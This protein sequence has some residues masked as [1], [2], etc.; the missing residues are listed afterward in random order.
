MI[1]FLTDPSVPTPGGNCP[2]CGAPMS[3]ERCAYCGTS[4]SAPRK[5]VGV[6]VEERDVQAVRLLHVFSPE[7]Q[8][9]ERDMR[10]MKEHEMSERLGREL[11]ENGWV[12]VRTCVNPYTLCLEIQFIL[13]VQRPEPSRV[14]EKWEDI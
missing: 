8:A 9:S 6:R 10:R 5:V 4:K 14:R 2:N 13:R 11:L 7:Y 12:E 3:G 1:P